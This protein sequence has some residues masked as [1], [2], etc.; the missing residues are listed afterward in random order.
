MTKLKP[1]RSEKQFLHTLDSKTFKKYA[2]I[3][4]EK[5]GGYTVYPESYSLGKLLDPKKNTGF[6]KFVESNTYPVIFYSHAKRPFVAIA[7]SPTFYQVVYSPHIVLNEDIIILDLKI[8]A[9][10]FKQET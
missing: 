4:T 5:F 3:V 1:I 9:N 7:L 6:I 8:A 10:E 2:S